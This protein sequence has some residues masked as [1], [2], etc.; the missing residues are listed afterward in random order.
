MHGTGRNAY[1]DTEGLRMRAGE[2]IGTKLQDI[3]RYYT[4]TW[5]DYRCLWLDQTN[6]AIHFG[7]DDGRPWS[8]SESL[9]NTN[10]VLADLVGI[11]PGDRVFDAGCGIGGSA[12]W[13]AENCGATVVG[14]TVVQAQVDRANKAVRRRGLAHAICIERS[15]YTAPSYPEGSFDVVWALES[16]CHATAKA[17]FYRQAAR[18][19]RPGG[20]L[21]VAEYA[22]TRRDLGED[23]EHLLTDWLAS[24][25]IPDLDTP[26]EHTAHA[27]AAGLHAVCVRD[28]TPNMTRSLRR[29]HR[30]SIPG[31]PISRM[32]HLLKLRSAVSHANVV[33]SHRQYEALRRGLWSYA[34]IT[35]VKP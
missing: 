13:L 12:I 16:L 33:G 9:K 28:A 7:Y 8:H 10:R 30:L 15:D 3:D 34:F 4:G 19:L 26:E 27:R 2:C 5:L 17:E 29:L 6:L 25:M 31:V 22:R 35:A 14:V 18:L 20:R 11:A 32:L 24:W 1:V 23:D 21:V